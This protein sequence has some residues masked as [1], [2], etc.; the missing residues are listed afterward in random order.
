MNSMVTTCK[1]SKGLLVLWTVSRNRTVIVFLL[2]FSSLISIFLHHIVPA[3]ISVIA[4][5]FNGTNGGLALATGYF[6]G[7]LICTTWHSKV[8]KA[9]FVSIW[10]E[11]VV[12]AGVVHG[13]THALFGTHALVQI[14]SWAYIALSEFQSNTFC[15]V[16]KSLLITCVNLEWKTEQKVCR[17]VQ[18]FI[19]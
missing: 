16:S 10:F 5:I 9:F 14:K 1:L 12:T 11:A 8:V 15:T 2:L 13:V 19:N 18:I 17:K 4:A 3:I 7:N 6:C